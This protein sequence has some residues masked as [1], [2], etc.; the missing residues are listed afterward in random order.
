MQ[1]LSFK[2][3]IVW[4]YWGVGSWGRLTL[5]KRKSNSANKTEVDYKLLGEEVL[6]MVSK[7]CCN[8]S[9]KWSVHPNQHREHGQIINRHAHLPFRSIMFHGQVFL[10]VV[11]SSCFQVFCCLY[12]TS[13]QF[14]CDFVWQQGTEITHW[15]TTE[16][17][18]MN[19]NE[20]F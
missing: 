17:N 18:V 7:L 1:Y 20:T 8:W 15:K 9:L 13:P 4:K 3:N 14:F 11:Q 19:Y 16:Q 2:Q 12:L 10:V 5:W 6:C